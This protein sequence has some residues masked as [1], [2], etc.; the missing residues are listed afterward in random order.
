MKAPI[1]ID[2]PAYLPNHPWHPSVI[3]T[4]DGFAG[5][6]WWMA[7]TP[8]PPFH[9]DPYRDR[10]E[11]PCI[12][13]SDD[14][15]HWKSAGAP[16]DDLTEEQIANHS[17]HS[18]P[19]LVMK[20]EELYCYYRLM[21]DHDSRTTIIRRQSRDGIHWSEREIIELKIEDWRLKNEVISPAIVWTGKKWRMYYVDD[22]YKNQERGIQ[23]AE[24]DDGVHFTHVCSA[25]EPQAVKP[26]HIDVQL[27][28]GRYYLLVHDVDHKSLTLYTS[29]D[30]MQW[31]GE[32]RY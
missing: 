22:T 21:E 29:T 6:R 7:E 17:Y 26:W 19:H 11:L 5:H 25:W 8:Y 28:D 18:D 2:I 24:S 1:Q 14:G 27:I 3:Y 20:D 4:A 30:G 13:Y 16:I 32:R 31:E 15:V 23:M 12:H 9:A 10:W